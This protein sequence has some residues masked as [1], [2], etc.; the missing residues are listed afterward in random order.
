MTL[1]RLSEIW[2]KKKLNRMFRP[3]LKKLIRKIPRSSLK[4]NCNRKFKPSIHNNKAIIMNLNKSRVFRVKKQHKVK[5]IKPIR[6]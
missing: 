2:G 6:I 1:I 5:L 4:T 3:M